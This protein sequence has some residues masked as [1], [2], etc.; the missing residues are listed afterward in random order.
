MLECYDKY[1][2]VMNIKPGT[3]CIPSVVLVP[4]RDLAK[5]RN[6]VKNLTQ[7][8]N[9]IAT[10]LLNDPVKYMRIGRNNRGAIDKDDFIQVLDPRGFTCMTPGSELLIN[11]SK[12]TVIN[13]YIQEEMVWCN[14]ASFPSLVIAGSKEHDKALANVKGKTK[15]NYLTPSKLKIGDIVEVSGE[16]FKYVY[17]GS[18]KLEFEM[19][20]KQMTP[21]NTS[22]NYYQQLA[23][24]KIIESKIFSDNKW[25]P[26]FYRLDDYSWD[27][28]IKASLKVTKVI[29]NAVSMV[30]PI[31]KDVFGIHSY[32]LPNRIIEL[33]GLK[34][35]VHSHTYLTYEVVGGKVK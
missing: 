35:D 6:R 12:L 19:K 3:G 34:I 22:Y 9:N 4:D 27:T 1:T 10:P 33:S 28:F 11:L 23:K 26:I 8:T 30:K 24:D 7:Y 14:N 25:C 18:H 5:Y 32:Y 29:R 20:L 13:G 2:M 17:L 16:D 21:T 31:P 15:G